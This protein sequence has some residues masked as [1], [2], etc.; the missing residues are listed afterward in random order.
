MKIVLGMMMIAVVIILLISFICFF[1]TFYVTKRQKTS[2]EEFPLPPGEIYEPY[3]PVMLAWMKEVRALPFGPVSIQS[4]DGLKLF[5]KYYECIPGAP[6]ELMLHGYRGS[7]ERDLC[8]GVQRA[9]A[10]GHNV[11]IVDQRASGAS[12]GRVIS[13]G[14]NESRDCRSWVDFIIARFGSDVKIILTGISMGAATVMIASGRDMPDNVV[15]VLADCGYSTAR[16]IIQQV[17]R[18]MKLPVKPIYPFIKLGARLYGRFDLEET[19][20]IESVRRCRLPIIF[21]HGDADDYVPHTMSQA[22][23]A[24][25]HTRKQLVIVPSAGHGLSYPADQEGYLTALKEFF[26]EI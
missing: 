2:T 15:G 11:L 23:Y 9:F 19:S 5:G 1:M 7:A 25:C 18:Q 17:I 26:S 6:I 20:P 10:L 16:E 24:A 22:N 12:E 8:G 13:F 14:I 4:F 3:Y 21:F